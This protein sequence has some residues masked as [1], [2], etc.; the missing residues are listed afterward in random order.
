MPDER[1]GD[2]LFEDLD[3][4]FA[5]IRDVDWDDDDEPQG[6]QPSEEHV[7]VQTTIAEDPADAPA[8]LPPIDPTPE[9][10]DEDVVEFEIAPITVDEE[11]DAEAAAP[12][13]APA[14]PAA[15][16]ASLFEDDDPVAAAA[17]EE[18]VEVSF[19]DAPSEDDL[20]AAAQHFT[21]DPDEHV[22]DR[23]DRHRGG[24]GVRPARRPRRAD[25]VEEDI[26]ADLH[27]SAGPAADRRGGRRGHDGT[28]VARR[29]RGRGGCRGGPPWERRG[30][31]RPR[32]VPDRA[33]P[34]RSSR[35]GRS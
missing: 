34:R 24:R 22:R 32:R 27:E 17:V 18:V 31:R 35:S 16:L 23:A 7:E 3:K 28:L 21:A 30:P 19:E 12:E 29:R 8:T 13:D 2:E 20:E 11:L 5:P 4:F 9:P 26:L 1:D 6:R 15:D 10:A 33:R 14:A 25:D